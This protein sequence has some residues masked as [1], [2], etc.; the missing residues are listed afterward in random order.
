MY[1]SLRFFFLLRA[2]VRSFRAALWAN[3]LRGSHSGVE[4]RT[5][6]SRKRSDG[7]AWESV[8]KVIRM[9]RFEPVSWNERAED[10]REEGM[11][12]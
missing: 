8:V 9:A 11:R 10:D 3:F 6:G 5:S 1:R 2:S 4:S 12:N 7:N